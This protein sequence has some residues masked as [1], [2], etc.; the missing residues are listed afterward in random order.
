MRWDEIVESKG[1]V[2][3]PL[4]KI[5]Q[6]FDGF[7]EL[8]VM[9]CW[10]FFGKLFVCWVIAVILHLSMYVTLICMDLKVK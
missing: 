1:S 6:I 7:M 10:E 8:E 5:V 3:G 2:G 4:G 9:E